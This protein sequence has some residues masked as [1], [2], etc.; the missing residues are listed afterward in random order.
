MEAT[1]Q[2][3]LHG[4]A[5]L[6]APLAMAQ[7]HP[8]IETLERQWM[9]AWMGADAK[10]LRKLTA[11]NFRMVMGSTPSAILD[12]KSWVEA[13]TKR[14]RCSAYRF[15]DIYVRDVG[16]MTVFATQL[17]I[18]ATMDGHDW[19]GTYWVTDLWRKSRVTR[20][21][22]MVER[23]ISRPDEKPDAAAAIRSLQLWR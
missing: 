9:R 5:H 8:I 1:P 13:A 11:R 16:P 23:I 14:Y 19:S 15:G 7:L 17:T 18:E 20:N 3:C 4:D 6:V 2:S 22:R 12:A 10:G 21:W